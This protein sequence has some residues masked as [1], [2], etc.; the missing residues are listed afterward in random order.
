MADVG[1]QESLNNILERMH[2]SI[3]ERI[4]NELD[5]QFR[6]EVNKRLGMKKGNIKI[7]MEEAMKMW[8]EKDSGV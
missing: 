5:K 8:I 2:G 7:A 6:N 3:R 1:L 4:D